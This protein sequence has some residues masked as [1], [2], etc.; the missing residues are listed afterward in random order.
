MNDRLSRNF[1]PELGH[2]SNDLNT[3]RRLTPDEEVAAGRLAKQG[4]N[5]ARDQ[6]LATHLRLVVRIALQYRPSV[7]HRV[8]LQ[9]MVQEGNVG[10]CYAIKKFDPERGIKFSTYA[11][12]WIRQYISKYVMDY[13][14]LMRWGTTDRQRK[15]FFSLRKTQQRLASMGVPATSERLAQEMD[16]P[17]PVVSEMLCRVENPERSIDVP[18]RKG[19]DTSLADLVQAAGELRP[20]ALV[21]AHELVQRFRSVVSELRP[22]LSERDRHLLDARY[23]DAPMTLK[24]FGVQH[25]ITRA[26]AQQLDARLSD[27]LSRTFRR[28]WLKKAA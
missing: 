14:R 26:R 12:T 6:L 24:E 28:T 22:T 23:G 5:R 27:L 3:C 4:D 17:E 20:D 18:M 9:D 11:A 25:G 19:T 7:S 13:S 1:V 16:V 10:L 15:V 21:E 2:Y 8:S